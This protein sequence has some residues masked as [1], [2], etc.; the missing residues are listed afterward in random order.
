MWVSEISFF[1][2][3]GCNCYINIQFV[4]INNDKDTVE[5]AASFATFSPIIQKLRTVGNIS[6]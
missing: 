5:I 6:K 1:L 3:G 4:L 2:G